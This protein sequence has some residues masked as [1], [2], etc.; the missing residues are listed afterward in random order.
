V[1]VRGVLFDVDGTLVDSNLAHA[2]AWHDAFVEAGLDGV[3]VERLLR[4]IGMGADKLLPTALGIEADSAMGKRLAKR[5]GEIFR[6]QHLP[7]IRPQPGAGELIRTLADRGLTLAV[8]SSAEPDELR[9]LLRIVGAEWL[10]DRAATSKDVKS[11]KPDPDVVHA[12]LG[13]IGLSPKEVVLIGDTPYDVEASR[14]A[15]IGAIALRCG[16]WG[17]ADLEGAAA[18]YDDPADLLAHLDESPLA[19]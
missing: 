16:G 8:A 14:R 15:G 5:R 18:V 17:D 4:L 1:S 6:E 11:S 12:A 2:Q 19:G 9:Q 7:R 3:D 13:E 10:A